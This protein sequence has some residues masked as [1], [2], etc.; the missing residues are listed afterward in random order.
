MTVDPS[1][2]LAFIEGSADAEKLSAPES[3]VLSDYDPS[4]IMDEEAISNGFFTAAKVQD[5][6]A[7]LEFYRIGSTAAMALSIDFNST[8]GNTVGSELAHIIDLSSLTDTSGKKMLVENLSN[9]QAQG[10][11]FA[12]TDVNESLDSFT[13]NP[14][15]NLKFNFNINN[16]VIST[17]LNASTENQLGLFEDE[18][19]AGI[20]TAAAV[21]EQAVASSTPGQI[22]VDDEYDFEI[23]PIA[24]YA[25]EADAA[26]ESSLL[27]EGS[28][29]VG[30][31]VEKQEIN[32]DGSLTNHSPI[33]VS[34]KNVKSVVDPHVRYGG[35]YLYTIKSV[36]LCRFEAIRGDPLGENAD[37][38]VIA[39][40]LV[41]SKGIN[42]TANCFE[43][44]PPPPPVDLKFHYDFEE[45]NLC[46][47][48][49]FPVNPQRDIKRFQIFRR[50]SVQDP[51]TILKE[52][53]FDDSES[54][55][56]TLESTP[57][58]LT[59]VMDYAS[60][61]YKD[62]EFTKE[63]SYI[64][65]V[66]SIDAR[67][68]TSN[69]ST[70]F[71]VEFDSFANKLK[72]SVISAE[73][74]PKS[75]PNLYLNQD[76]FVDTMKDSGHSRITLYFDPEYLDVLETVS[77]EDSTGATVTSESS[78]SLISQGLGEVPDYKLQ[79][80]N[81]DFQQSEIVEIYTNNRLVSIGYDY[82]EIS[83]IDLKTLGLSSLGE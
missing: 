62:D 21:Q 46:I 77:S 48:W 28:C 74:A 66:C 42:I 12:S 17:L 64:Y 34:S 61:Y 40:V 23:V 44:V 60:T 52:Y 37:Q 83:Q 65:A 75:Y 5:T 15:R 11:T 16:T 45:D 55:S 18:L 50:S 20:A 70:Q 4:V 47:L 27:N 71:L 13:W 72:I 49:D 53:D 54:K 63:S 76:L 25:I 58:T 32:T 30:Y 80:I 36:A 31:I 59:E 10:V 81:T 51:F 2:E 22:L 6:G 73:E 79:I 3:V 56:N 33:I 57:A 8:S 26:A 82:A 41:K 7:D 43:S 39:D 78:L 1:D 24:M 67:G 68:L 19:R 35:A 69:Y 29:L 9:L 14:V 38:L